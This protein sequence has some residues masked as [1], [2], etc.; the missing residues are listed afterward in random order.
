MLLILLFMYPI[1]YSV[2]IAA[3]IFEPSPEGLASPHFQ[4]LQ[5]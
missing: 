3:S 5:K 1:W 4:N 2:R